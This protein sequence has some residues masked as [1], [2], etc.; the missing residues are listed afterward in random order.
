MKDSGLWWIKAKSKELEAFRRKVY[1]TKAW[2]LTRAY[3]LSNNPFCVHCERD[4]GIL[5]KAVDVDHILPLNE[6]LISGNH[7]LAYDVENLQPLC[8]SCHSKK[9]Y[10]ESLNKN[11]LK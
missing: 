7:D 10:T 8:K 11:K 4:R 1:N 6:I 9:S 2:K 3:V 5:T